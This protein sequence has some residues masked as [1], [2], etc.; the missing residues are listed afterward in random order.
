MGADGALAACDVAVLAGGLG[1]R[2]RGVLDD[3]PKILAPIAGRPFLDRLLDQLAAA[4]ARRVLLLL[5]HRADQVATHLAAYPRDDIEIVQLVEDRPLGT[6]G[7]LRAAIPQLHS[8]PV[9]VINGDT[10]IEID[11]AAFLRDFRS[12]GAAASLACV[13]VADAGRYGSMTID[14]QSR[15]VGFAEKRT[16]GGAGWINAGLYLLS[17]RFLARLAAGSGPSLERDMLACEPARSLQA[18]RVVGRFIDIGT[19]ESLQAAPDVIA[20]QSGK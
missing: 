13:E 6:A 19:P 18:F 3:R 4:G 12:C 17:Q 14:T 7:A 8:D 16:G 15:V 9:L 11:F 2:L 20:R 5:G 10:F 1:T